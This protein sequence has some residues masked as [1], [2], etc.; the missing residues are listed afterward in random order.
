MITPKIAAS[1]FA[2]G[3]L[4]FNKGLSCLSF[5]QEIDATDFENL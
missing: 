5:L 4:Y 1:E 3:F 2:P